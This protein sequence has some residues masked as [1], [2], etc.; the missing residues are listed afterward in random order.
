[1]INRFIF[2]ILTTISVGA[3]ADPLWHCIANNKTGAEWNQFAPTEQSARSIVEKECIPQNGGKECPIVCFPPRIYYRC[4]AHDIVPVLKDLKPGEDQPK[5]GTWYW[6]SFSKQVAING[7][8][9][10]CRHNSGFGGCY[11]DPK[12]CASS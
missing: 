7:A 10:A 12:A 9:D 8:R 4:L 11:V 3:F 6:T 5:Q 2:F 1:M